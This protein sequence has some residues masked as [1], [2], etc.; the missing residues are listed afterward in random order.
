MGKPI[1]PP[2]PPREIEDQTM[3][4]PGE[5]WGMAL[6]YP[7][8]ILCLLAAYLGWVYLQP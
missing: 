3:P 6:S 2:P 8:L 1:V 7:V 4:N 5:S